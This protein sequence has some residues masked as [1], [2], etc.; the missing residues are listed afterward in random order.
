MISN[1]HYCSTRRTLEERGWNLTSRLSGETTC[2]IGLIGSRHA[3]FAEMKESCEHTRDELAQSH[4]DLQAH[5]S[6]HGC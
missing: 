6:H 5:R 1:A 3:A 4:R 2:L